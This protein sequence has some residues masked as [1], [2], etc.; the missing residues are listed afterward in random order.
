MA[1]KREDFKTVAAALAD[2][3]APMLAEALRLLETESLNRSEKFI[4][5]VRWLL[6]L[7]TSRAALKGTARD[8]VLWR[9]IASAPDGFCH[10]RA[11]VVGSL[12]EDIADGK[13]FEAVR[14]AFAA[15]TQSLIYQR[16]QAAP[17]AGNVAAAEKI[18]EAL[19]IAPSLERRF[20]RI[21]D[22]ETIWMPAAPRE[23]PRTGG[24][25]GH[26]K[27]KREAAPAPLDIPAV[28]VTWMKFMQSVP[29]AERMQY[30]VDSS[31]FPGIAFTAAV[32]PDS[33]ELFK[34]P[35]RV[36]WYVHGHPSSP[37]VWNLS[38]RTWA[39]VTC[40]T[41]LPPLWGDNPQPFLG[42]GA[43]LALAGCVDTREGGGMA[44][45]PECLKGELHQVRSTI[46][47]YSRSAI[48]ADREL[49]TACGRDIRKGQPINATVRLLK[50]GVWTAYTIDRWD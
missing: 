11:S 43:M 26:L 9:A 41:M 13:S 2:F 50:G 46:E 42:E 32:N 5:P 38:A 4:A 21:E 3:T 47:A 23:A 6:D 29:G 24:V 39:D 25:F 34:W 19:G 10:P 33:P 45:F 31:A 44:L 28:R 15:K 40:I 20:A 7:H 8:N 12:L 36:A 30:L 49:A 48:L 1:A 37:S 27:P 16:P 17:S 14:G 35:G 22:L 18:V